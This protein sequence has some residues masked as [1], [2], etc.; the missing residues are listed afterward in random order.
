MCRLVGQKHK[1]DELL[2]AASMSHKGAKPAHLKAPFT[3]SYN[4]EPSRN[5]NTRL[6]ILTRV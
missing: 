1:A 3:K 4:K 5:T 6:Y 2:P